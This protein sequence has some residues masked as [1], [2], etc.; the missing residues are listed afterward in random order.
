[1]PN[2]LT[3][4]SQLGL[5]IGQSFICSKFVTND[6]LPASQSGHLYHSPDKTGNGFEQ[7]QMLD[8]PPV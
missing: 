7:Q 1:M 8:P 2:L 6:L 4:E 5:S 3:T